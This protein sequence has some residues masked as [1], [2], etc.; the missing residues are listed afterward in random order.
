ML[1]F[2]AFAGHAGLVVEGTRFIYS[3]DF[4]SLSVGLK[5][6][7]QKRLLVKVTVDNS[8]VAG[9]KRNQERPP[10]IAMP[11]LFV[12]PAKK[13]GMLRIVYVADG[14]MLPQDRETVFTLSVLAIPSGKPIDNNVQLA[15]KQN[16]KLFYRPKK[17]KGSSEDAYR[18]LVWTRDKAG[19]TIKNTTAYYATLYGLRINGQTVN[20]PGVIEPFGTRQERWCQQ[21]QTCVI[22]WSSLSDIG[23][24]MPPIN[25]SIK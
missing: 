1:V 7:S 23:K 10:F 12:V 6:T 4:K 8:H 2:I 3:D 24:I 5:N 14:R 21:S 20:R 25:V 17:L 15:I 18:S 13:E 11:P 9:A 19:V 16:F 22:S